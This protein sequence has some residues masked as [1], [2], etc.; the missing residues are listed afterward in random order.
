[1][2]WDIVFT[3]KDIANIEIYVKMMDPMEKLF[4]SLNSGDLIFPILNLAP[5]QS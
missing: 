5:W 2:S 4:S 1:M 3:S